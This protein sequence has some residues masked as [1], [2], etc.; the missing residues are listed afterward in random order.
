[1][2]VV[3]DGM[4]CYVWVMHTSCS[5]SL[6]NPGGWKRALTHREK[7]SAS[8]FEEPIDRKGNL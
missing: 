4:H 3:G 2:I 1:M 5:A 6:L 8:I 7:N